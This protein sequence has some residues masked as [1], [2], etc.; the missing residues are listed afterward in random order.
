RRPKLVIM[1]SRWGSIAAAILAAFGLTW[2]GVRLLTPSTARLLAEAYHEQRS[3]DFRIAGAAYAPIRQQR[4][5]ASA[6]TSPEPLLKAQARL[7][8]AIKS[9]PDDPDILRLQGEAEMI[10]RQAAS[11]VRI[12]ERAL[13]LRPQDPAILADLGAAYALRAELE[14]Q[15]GDRLAALEYL[16]RSL[17]TR[18]KAPEVSFNRALILERMLL[19]DQA[20]QEWENYLKLDASSD[21]ANEAR[22]HLA[23]LN[24]RLR[25]RE[26]ALRET[27]G[28]PARFLAAAASGQPVDA[29]TLLRDYAISQW[30]PRIHADDQAQA[31]IRRLAEILKQQHGDSWLTDLVASKPNA[32]ALERLAEARVANQAGH[33]EAAPTAAIAA[34]Q[35]FQFGPGF[36]W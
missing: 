19:K 6:F 11:A 17:H 21:W 23:D 25:A 28:D 15:P 32:A 14:R 31:A 20:V 10:A 29:E 18:P 26:Q 1:A 2:I 9:S 7:A 8:G 36:L 34:Q 22:K 35:G 16:S 30:L 13:D 33:A 3:F 4:S 24:A 5:G 12:L 27:S